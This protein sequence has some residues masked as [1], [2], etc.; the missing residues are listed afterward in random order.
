[1]RK[2]GWSSWARGARGARP[3]EAEARVETARAALERFEDAARQWNLPED[4]VAM[5]RER[6]RQHIVQLESSQSADGDGS[7][8][9]FR[10][11]RVELQLID[12]ERRRLNQLVNESRI[13][14]EIRRRIERDLDLDEER[15]RRNVRG[16]APDEEPLPVRLPWR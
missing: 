12:A 4:L 9:A 3:S 5:R 8:L 10:A 16:A 7:D 1:V 15:L 6:Q 11:H 2:L 13:T 14:D